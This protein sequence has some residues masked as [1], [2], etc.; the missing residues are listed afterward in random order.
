MLLLA[1][2]HLLGVGDQEE[3]AQPRRGYPPNHLVPKIVVKVESHC[4]PKRLLRI[5]F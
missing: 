3:G 1:A 2:H 5:D 4:P